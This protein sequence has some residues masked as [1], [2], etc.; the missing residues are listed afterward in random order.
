MGSSASTASNTQELV[1]SPASTTP[2]GAHLPLVLV[3]DVDLPGRAVRLDYQDID[4][5]RGQLVIAHMNDAA[6]VIADLRN[7]AVLRRLTGI[8]TARGIAA[9]SDAGRIFVTSS[10]DR[11]VIID[12][13]SLTET[14]RF[15]TGHGPDGVAW[16]PAHKMVGVSDQNDGALSLIADAGV[17]KRVQIALGQETGNVVFDPVRGWFWITV[18]TS[19]PPDQLVAIDPAAA[20]VMTRIGLPGCG[21]A[22]GLRLHPD[23]ASAFIACERNSLLA[24]V[25]LNGPHS[26]ATDPTGDG[27]DVLS[28]DS[29]LGWLYVAAE[30]GNLT[31]FDIAR[32][33]L[34]LVGHDR[35][36]DNAHSVAVDPTTHRAFFPLMSGPKRTPVLR[37]MRPSG[38]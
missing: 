7:G 8:P 25:D 28:I 31:V 20:K 23:G 14:G 12:S 38:V 35:P 24:R 18:V 29:G 21:G 4:A 9:A 26:V 37:I 10:P 16:D 27:P 2:A 17:G 5:Q 19:T 1:G 33:G 11:L 22:H 15:A 6:V 13:T 36:G 32:P 30:N 3:A 34:V